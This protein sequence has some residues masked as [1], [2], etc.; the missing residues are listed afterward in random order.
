MEDASEAEEEIALRPFSEIEPKP[1]QW[2]WKDRVPRG[3]LTLFTGIPGLGKSLSTDDMAARVSRGSPWPDRSGNAPLGDVIILCA[4]DSSEHTI[5]PRLD[6]AGADV[7]RVHE[8]RAFT[9]KAKGRT[10]RQFNLEQDVV[11]LR[12][13]LERYPDTKL[14]IIDP[15]SAY[16]GET[17]EF[18]DADVR[19]ML[20]PLAKLADDM[21]IAVIGIKHFNKASD[22][23]V[24]FRSSG[25]IAY[26]AMARAAWA[27]VADPSDTSKTLML[28]IKSNLGPKMDGLAFRTVK[29][30]GALAPRVEW[31]GVTR[32]SAEEALRLKPGP[33]GEQLEEAKQFLREVLSDGSEL[34]NEIERQAEDAGLSWD[35]VKRAKKELGIFSEKEGVQGWRWRLEADVLAAPLLLGPSSPL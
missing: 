8:L 35:T 14:I 1:G 30:E 28:M 12:K 20:T 16:I 11:R 18:K 32:V 25:S 27:F 22:M 29:L 17:N 34:A 6:E 5:R 33:K 19:R 15:V 31:L 9:P 4:E 2:L 24:M 26:V 23:A 21:G 7:S 3:A 10:E 13:A